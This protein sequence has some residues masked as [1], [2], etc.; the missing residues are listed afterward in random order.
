MTSL[1]SNINADSYLWNT[2]ETTPQIEV[3]TSGTYWLETRIDNCTQRDTIKVFYDDDEL[4]INAMI[5]DCIEQIY[6]L[7]SNIEAERYLWS[8]GEIT[9]DI[10]V[11]YTDTYWLEVQN[12]NCTYSD[13]ID[14]RIDEFNINLPQ[15]TSICKGDTL[16]ISIANPKLTLQWQDGYIG[17]PRLLTESGTYA[18]TISTADCDLSNDISLVIDDCGPSD[19]NVYI[20]NAISVNAMTSENKSLRIYANC[21][22]DMFHIQIFDRW[23]NLIHIGTNPE[24]PWEQIFEGERISL[25]VYIIKLSYRLEGENNSKVVYETLSLL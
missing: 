20:P 17:T 6:G 7:S 13:S 9:R 3:S 19:C 18:Y 16:S 8:T 24:L 5:Q 23:G 4:I 15:D 14:L 25:G 11:E 10:L 2:G 22:V 12:G 1:S 21:E